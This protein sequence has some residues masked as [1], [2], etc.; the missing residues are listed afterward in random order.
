MVEMSEAH[1]RMPGLALDETAQEAARLALLKLLGDGPL[2]RMGMRE[3]AA[4]AGLG[5]ATLYKY[6]GPKETLPCAVLAP[7]LEGLIADMDLASRTA[8][9]V[10]ARL[11]A[12]LEAMT[13]FAGAQPEAAR[14]IW[15]HLPDSLW[16]GA[17]PDWRARRLRIVAHILRNGQH[18]GS[19]REDVEAEALARLILGAADAALAARLAGTP[20]QDL[21]DALWPM[22]AR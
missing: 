19:V 15:R 18:D 10:K 3:A 22:A 11:R 8:V 9:G 2:E 13:R 7:E 12:V 16:D 1:R 21:F 14:A 6:F 20:A 5:L 4:A 17:E